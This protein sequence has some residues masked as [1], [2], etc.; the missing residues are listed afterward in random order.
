M[1]L[2]V[3]GDEAGDAFVDVVDIGDV[4]RFRI[5]HD[6]LDPAHRASITVMT[7]LLEKALAQAAKL[8]PEEQDALAAVILDEIAD[9]ERWATT[10]AA[11]RAK[12][13]TLADEALAEHADKRTTP[14][15]LDTEH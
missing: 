6:G 9:D 4:R 12:L 5:G 1:I 3:P 2:A 10:F 13:E 11:S 7:K 14:L 8:S 15:D